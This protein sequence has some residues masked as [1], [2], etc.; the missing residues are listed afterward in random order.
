MQWRRKE[1]L[2]DLTLVSATRRSLRAAAELHSGLQLQLPGELRQELRQELRLRQ[3]PL[4]LLSS[5]SWLPFGC[6]AHDWSV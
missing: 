5:A 6:L 4:R 2:H 3:R 1:T